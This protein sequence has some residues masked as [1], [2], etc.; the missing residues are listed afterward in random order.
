MLRVPER[1]GILDARVIVGRVG[2]TH[3]SLSPDGHTGLVA[4][5]MKGA[6][7]ATGDVLIFLDSHVEV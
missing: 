3:S 1:K 4:A 5:R 7:A 6:R 2:D